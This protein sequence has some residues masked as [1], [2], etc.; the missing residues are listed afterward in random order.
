MLRKLAL[1]RP[2]QVHTR[3][4]NNLRFFFFSGE[5]TIIVV[6][7]VV[8]SFVGAGAIVITVY[9]IVIKIKRKKNKAVVGIVKT[10]IEV[11]PTIISM[12]PDP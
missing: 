2:Q 11:T 9:I 8:G 12:K 5:E 6:G 10:E 4:L 3:A 1:C 7:V